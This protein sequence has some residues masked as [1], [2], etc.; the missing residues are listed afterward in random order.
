MKI[1]KNYLL[2]INSQTKTAFY[3]NSKFENRISNST[4]GLLY[5]CTLRELVENLKRLEEEGYTLM[6][7]N[8]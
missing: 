7:M 6:K 8:H 1:K 4:L 3:G 2:Y 5:D